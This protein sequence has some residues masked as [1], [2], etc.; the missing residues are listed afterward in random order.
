MY[1][2]FNIYL[3]NCRSIPNKKQEL[4]TSWREVALVCVCETFMSE[5][6]SLNIN[7]TNNFGGDR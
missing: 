5:D 7:D 1:L 2:A 6:K 4:H 3:W